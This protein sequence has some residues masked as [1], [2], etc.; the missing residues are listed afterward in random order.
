MVRKIE[1]DVYILSDRLKARI[2]YTR[3]TNMV[4]LVFHFRD[5]QIPEGAVANVYMQKP[6]GKAVYNN[7]T[8]EGNDII[9]NATKQMFAELGN[10]ALQ[11][12]LKKDGEELVTF[13]QPV[14]VK[15]NYTAGDFQSENESGFFEEYEEKLKEATEKANNAAENADEK[16]GKAETA[17][18]NANEATN[19]A[20]TA[21]EAA[22][23]GAERANTAAEAAEAAAGNANE[24]A[25]EANTAA[26][27]ANK[28]AQDVKEKA[29]NG[30]FTG[31]I[32][33]GNV[34]TGLP[35]TEASVTNRGT[36][37]HAVLDMTI[38]EGKTGQV[39][40]IDTVTIEFEQAEARENINSGENFSGIF[41]K[42]KK[43]FADLGTA[44]FMKTANNLVTTGEGFLLDARQGKA[45]DDK[46]SQL[47]NMLQ[48]ANNQI[49]Q[50]I[51]E[52][53]EAR[54]KITAL[55]SKQMQVSGDLSDWL[56]LKYP[57]GYIEAH[58]RYQ[59]TGIA[60]T[61]SAGGQYVSGTLWSGSTPVI[62]GVT[63]NGGHG[64]A[65]YGSRSAGTYFYRLDQ[66]N[67]GAGAVRC[68]IACR[69]SNTNVNFPA[70]IVL[71]GTWR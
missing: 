28:V 36:E 44:A 23:T 43:W 22:N 30:E 1:R 67:D 13:E 25:N 17:A 46:A 59:Y 41:G 24:A 34:T 55:E 31:T 39:E 53:S 9:V 18:G 50:L 58:R 6:S 48:T 27:A 52:L 47:L 8:I 11:I 16:A 14:L 21:A 33:I 10:S 37:Q 62:S 51:N 4:D 15:Q 12:R 35:G 29:E 20:N 68:V 19:E 32:K 70:H 3:A 38:P 65:S 66:I 2:E 54:V 56:I 7:A 26:E 42:V 60:T 71:T 45:L 61:T 49:S 5:Y 57:N 64:M 69:I 63:W 40:N